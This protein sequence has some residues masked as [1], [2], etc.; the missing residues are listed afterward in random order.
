MKEKNQILE[1]AVKALNAKKGVDIE[2][3]DVSGLTNIADWFVLASGTSNI[4]VKTLVDEVE[5]Q[6]KQEQ[7]IDPKRVEGYPTAQW[8]LMDYGDVIV[9][10]FHPEARE[11]YSLERLYSEG[12]R[13]EIEDK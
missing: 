5:E 10:V 3:I 12:A 9:H 1:T 13:M 6:L 2:V 7:G 8:I 4:H 11:F